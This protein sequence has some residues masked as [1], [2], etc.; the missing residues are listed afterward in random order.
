MRPSADEAVEYHI[1]IGTALDIQVMPKSV[2]VSTKPQ[3]PPVVAIDIPSAEH[4]TEN[5][6]GKEM[7]A[8][9]L[10]AVQIFPKFVEVYNELDP[11]CTPAISLLPSADDAMEFQEFA[12]ALVFVQV[13]PEFV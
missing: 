8:G 2:E 9:G 10:I 4:A 5:E 12:G 11:I 7:P 1:A 3:V 13:I 6:G